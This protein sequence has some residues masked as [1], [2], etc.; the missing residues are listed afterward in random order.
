M[1]TCGVA[2][3]LSQFNRC[4]MTSSC[5]RELWGEFFLLHVER[6]DKV[7]EMMKKFMDPELFSWSACISKAEELLVYVQC[8]RCNW[9]C[10]AGRLAGN[11]GSCCSC[12]QNYQYFSLILQIRQCLIWNNAVLYEEFHTWLQQYIQLQACCS[13]VFFLHHALNEN[14]WS[15]S[16]CGF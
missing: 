6:K 15:V 10:C 14:F 5:L 8:P 3:L 11:L 13:K 2:K 1:C 16:S 4:Q 7:Q 9:Y 12:Q